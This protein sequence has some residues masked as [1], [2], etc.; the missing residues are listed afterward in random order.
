VVAVLGLGLLVPLVTARILEPSPLGQGTHQQLGLEPCTVMVLF[1]RRCPACG[2]TTAWANLVRGR[3]IAALR[4]NVGGTL[5]GLLTLLAVPWLLLSAARGRWLGWVPNSTVAAWVAGSILA[6]M[7]I[8]WGL[9]LWL[10]ES[11]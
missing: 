6:V 1:G 4:A 9:R 10:G 3:L 7:L 5:L 11:G 2:A 8:D